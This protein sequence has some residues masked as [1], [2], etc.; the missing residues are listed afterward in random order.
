MK[1]L[2]QLNIHIFTKL[3]NNKNKLTFNYLGKV[4]KIET[5]FNKE[6][7]CYCYKINDIATDIAQYQY[8]EALNYIFQHITHKD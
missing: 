8:K 5:F 3:I 4:V 6:E 7:D 2:E 1:T